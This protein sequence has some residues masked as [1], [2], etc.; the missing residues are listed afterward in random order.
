M[1]VGGMRRRLALGLALVGA[2]SAL[3]GCTYLQRRG[4]DASHMVDI[5]V[6][7]TKTPQYSFYL[8]AAGLA[9][10]GAGRVNGTFSGI[11]GNQVGTVRHY[12][13]TLGL[14]LWSYEE[15]GW[16][17]FDI[18]K[19]ETLYCQYVGLLGWIQ[20]L[21]RRPGYAPGCI[22]CIH[23][24]YGGFILN[25]RYLEILDFLTGWFGLDLCGDDAGGFG[26]WPWQDES[27]K[28]LPPRASLGF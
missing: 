10:A 24:G 18:E 20:H 4:S 13:K 21:A 26:H 17:D 25:L 6:T 8:C 23:L 11:G 1:R 3:S 7:W 28:N 9:S 19:Q 5:G 12:E 22:H 2:V 16:G 27:A 15:I 14:L